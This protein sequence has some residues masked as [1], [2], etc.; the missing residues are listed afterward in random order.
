MDA[1]YLSSPFDRKQF[2]SDAYSDC[3]EHTYAYA[4][5]HPNTDCDCDIHTNSNSPA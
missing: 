4:N 5:T 3:H 2:Q 1:L